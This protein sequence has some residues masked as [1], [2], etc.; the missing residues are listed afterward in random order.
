LKV[1]VTF[2]VFL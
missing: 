1:E 2:P